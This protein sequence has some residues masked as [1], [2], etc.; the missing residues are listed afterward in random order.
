MALVEHEIDHLEHGLEALGAVDGARHRERD[1]R[2]RER[3]LRAYDPL[4][5]RRLRDDERA[6]DLRGGQPPDEPQRQRDA[7]LGRQDRMARG[8]HQAQEIVADVVVERIG[9]GVGAVA[10]LAPIARELGVLGVDDPGAAHVVERAPLRGRHQP[11]ARVVGHAIGRPALE[12]ED[13]RVLCELLG[14]PEITREPREPGHEARELD[15]KHRGD[16][17]VWIDHAARAYP[18]DALARIEVRR[19]E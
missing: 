16:R 6:R 5:D 3:T 11:R 17:V 2:I 4:P 7:L 18:L 13:E 8:E 14:A 15:A 10:W 1:P 9:D 12:R 19:I